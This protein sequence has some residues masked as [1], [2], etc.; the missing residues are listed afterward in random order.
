MPHAT[1]YLE[2]KEGDSYPI[3]WDSFYFVI[4]VFGIDWTG[5]FLV[6]PRP[7]TPRRA[8]RTTPLP[9]PPGLGFLVPIIACH[10]HAWDREAGPAQTPTPH[11]CNWLPIVP[12]PN[13]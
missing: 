2:R 3:S 9:D 11:G 7:P 8:P 4:F 10:A 12:H 1:I 13:A 5:T 6:V